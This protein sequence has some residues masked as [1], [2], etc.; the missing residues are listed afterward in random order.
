VIKVTGKTKIYGLVGWPVVHTF[1]P[2]MHNAAFKALG[3]NAVY[4]P[5]PVQE[6]NLKFALKGLVALGFCGVNITIP[7]KEKVIPYLSKIERSASLVGAVNTIIIKENKLLG[8][9]TDWIGFI[10]SLKKDVK[11][12][13]KNKKAFILGAGGAARAVA[14]ALANCG[15]AY[16]W[17][18]DLVSKKASLLTSHIN[19]HF[20]KTKAIFVP[21]LK[22]RKVRE[23]LKKVDLVVNATGVGMHK[24][25]SSLVKPDW[26]HKGQLAYDLIYNPPLTN[27]LKVYKKG[28]AKILNGEG[29]LLYQGAEAFRLFT[30]RPAPISVMR[31]ALKDQVTELRIK[32]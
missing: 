29:L 12:N 31:K 4:L 18:T 10:T 5:L 28:K 9:N 16:L 17:I 7:Y 26:V 30:S 22:N 19:R 21:T 20:K 2:P 1:S 3:I 27:F 11:F 13:P 23:E 32:Y 8:Y 14:V 25:D 15:V 6:K 24:K